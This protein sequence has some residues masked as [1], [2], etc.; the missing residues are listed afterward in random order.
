MEVVV[1]RAERVDPAAWVW[2]AQSLER[3]ERVRMPQ[4]RAERVLRAAREGIETDRAQAVKRVAAAE[5]VEE[6]WGP[7]LS[8]GAE[9]ERG[10]E[11]VALEG[12]EGVASAGRVVEEVVVQAQLGGGSWRWWCRRSWGGRR[13]W[14]S[15][16]RC[17]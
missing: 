4:G 8:L 9:G 17:W 16:R 6:S 2:R 14:G 12:A 1:E 5:R 7:L 15:D 10:R 3:A 11:L 13:S